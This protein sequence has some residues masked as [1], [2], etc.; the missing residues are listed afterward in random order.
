MIPLDLVSQP[1]D[2]RQLRNAL[3]RF[4]TGVTVITTR[5]ASGKADGLTANSFCA[6]SL[7]PP[8]V[9]WSLRRAATAMPSFRESGAFAVNVLAVDQVALARQFAESSSNKFDGVECET[10][11]AGCPLI[12]G[13]LAHFE[14]K[15]QSMFDCGDHVI[16]VGQIEHSSFRDGE[17]LI[18]S[19]GRYC[20][21]SSAPDRA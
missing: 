5:T 21:L 4:A 18:F 19:G 16:L 14:C 17:P 12:P 8:L 10:G 3:S 6:V 13:C 2:Q 15:T 9:L 20:A 11:A 1:V 7:E